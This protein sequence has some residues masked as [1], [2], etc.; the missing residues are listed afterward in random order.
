MATGLPSSELSDGE[1]VA[2]RKEGCTPAKAGR[3]SCRKGSPAMGVQS[4]APS[5]CVAD[6]G[7]YVA[8]RGC[9]HSATAAAAS[10]AR[11]EGGR[12]ESTCGCNR[13]RGETCLDI[14]R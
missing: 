5:P 3:Y 7:F 9:V 13:K 14:S 4:W 1:G 11:A 12:G 8:R 6:G 2:A 10:T